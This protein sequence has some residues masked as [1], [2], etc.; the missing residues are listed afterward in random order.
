MELRLL[1]ILTV[2]IPPGIRLFNK[3]GEFREWRRQLLLDRKTLG[4]VPTMGALHKGHLALVEAAKKQCD[5]VALTIFVN[6]AQFAP[7]EDLAS[8]PRTLQADL[9]KLES[10]QPAAVLVPQIDEMY[11]SGIEL[12]VSK[13]VGPFVEVKGLS[14]QLEG[15]TRP[16]FFRGV[17]TVVSKLL[18]IMHVCPTIR[19]SDGLAMSSRNMYLTLNER[20]HALVLYNA[21]RAV[22]ELYNAGERH[23]DVLIKAAVDLVA[24]DKE[25]KLDYISINSG[26]D[27]SPLTEVKDGFVVSGAVFLGKSK[28]VERKILAVVKCL[29]G[30]REY[31]HSHQFAPVTKACGLP[32][33]MSLA[34][35]KRLD[36]T[37]QDKVSYDQ[38]LSGWSELMRMSDDNESLLFNILRKPDAKT[39]T[40]DDFLPVLEDVV[41]N[42]PG[43]QFLGN[44]TMF[45]ERYI[46]TVICRIYH[47]AN[48]PG[49]RLT[50]AQFRKCGFARVVQSLVPE[51]DLNTTQD[52]FSYKHFYVFYCKFWTLDTDHDL[53]LSEEDLAQYNQGSLSTQVV[54]RIIEY[55]HIPAFANHNQKKN[56]ISY[57]EYIWFLLSE[58]DKSTPMA[59]E[60]W[61]RC[62]D[63][64][65]D[66]ILSSYELSRFWKD[67]EERITIS[68]G[69]RYRQLSF[70]LNPEE[71]IQF[72]DIMRQLNDLVQPRKPGLF[73]LQDLK[74]QPFVAERFFDTFL[75]FDRF[76]IHESYQGLIRAKRLYESKQESSSGMAESNI[77]LAYLL[78]TDWIEYAEMEYEQII[79]NE[80]YNSNNDDD[81]DD[82]MDTQLENN[83]GDEITVIHE[84]EVVPANMDGP[85]YLMTITVDELPT[86]EEHECGSS[87]GSSSDLSPPHTPNDPTSEPWKKWQSEETEEEKEEDR[88]AEWLSWTSTCTRNLA[89]VVDK[90][91]LKE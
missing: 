78:L 62:M 23:V 80:Q 25:V 58:V 77:G 76:Q 63:L 72:D 41:T 70:G 29:Y 30:F 33:Y 39:L 83:S 50:M 65:G 79:M 17:A 73:R 28:A 75:S 15:V 90:T 8:Y 74:R 44:H 51:V 16:H 19:E 14:H 43:L 81:H 35:F 86:D 61:F 3:I 60:Y 85:V 91:T 6:P 52:Y 34:L 18:N 20:Q 71:C 59:I 57:L 37:R 54:K 45:Q 88:A 11:P 5:H 24:Q 49:G 38:F 69:V 42:H 56:T 64:D 4:Y 26:K 27:L 55:G 82:D 21:L 7:H 9:E 46:E 89:E 40:P 22:E 48:C 36:S 31:F 2:R 1:F 10:F 12:D 87:T 53:I 13:Q 67:Q 32:V 84:E 47:D 68:M 66:G